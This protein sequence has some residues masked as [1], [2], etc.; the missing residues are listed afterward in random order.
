MTPKRRLLTLALGS[1]LALGV[2]VPAFSGPYPAQN[3][4]KIEKRSQNEHQKAESAELKAHQRRERDLYGNT[5]AIRQ[6]QKAERDQLK[7]HQKSEKN[8]L[9]AHQKSER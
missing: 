9:K 3:H 2:S 5:V 8:S 1:T 7:P 6:H 4:Q